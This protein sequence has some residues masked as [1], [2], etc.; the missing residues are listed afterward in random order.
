MTHSEEKPADSP[1]PPSK[2]NPMQV[3]GSVFAAGLGV[4]S[5]KNRERDFKQG[6]I[7]IFIAA[8]IIFTLG[9]IGAVILVVQIVL[10]GAGE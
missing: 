4:Q 10:K 7:G 9:F 6:R 1:E 2:L 5:S 3:V 8:G